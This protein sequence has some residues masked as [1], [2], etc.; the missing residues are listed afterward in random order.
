M[1][2]DAGAAGAPRFDVVL[3]GYDRR[4]VDE[5]VARLQRVLA[6]MRDDI[7]AGRSRPD[8]VVP[9]PPGPA[10]PTPRPRPTQQPSAASPDMIGN[11]SD[12][13]Q[14]ILA[15][16]EEE[17]AE[18]RKKALADRDAARAELAA[19]ARQRDA[20]LT[21]LNRMRGQLEGML[22]APTARIVLPTREMAPREGSP[23]ERSLPSPRPRDAGA[24]RGAP[25]PGTSAAGGPQGQRQDR[26]GA[27]GHGGSGRSGPGP[28]GSP[29]PGPAQ[30]PR[31]DVG[32]RAMSPDGVTQPNQGPQPNQG[33]EPQPSAQNGL[34]KNDAQL[35]ATE[36][37]GSSAGGASDVRPSPAASSGPARPRP[38]PSSPPRTTDGP[39]PAGKRAAHRLPTGAYPAVTEAPSMR[40]RNEPEAQPGELFRPAS[41][42]TDHSVG[43]S[44][45]QP[46]AQTV[47]AG[48]VGSVSGPDP[49]VPTARPSA[50]VEATTK[51]DSVRPSPSGEATVLAP[52]VEPGRSGRSES[53]DDTT[54]RGLSKP[55]DA[56]SGDADRT[57]RSTSRSRSG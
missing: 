42:Q 48:P 41:A 30:A 39:D 25:T 54:D 44:D 34:R 14:S 38:R 17:A 45:G 22:A 1:T 46:G 43:G 7:E 35:D 57:N 24:G 52:A 50:D 20:V 13:M 4:Q 26:A 19:L 8:P 51:V 56:A 31:P 3:R 53:P 29:T 36:P 12:R 23:Q 27:Q 21:D 5:H 6:R 32:S 33:R 40:P 2:A 28:G 10:R 9:G 11:F 47:A 37:A 18:I 55:D 15:G 49:M 16:A